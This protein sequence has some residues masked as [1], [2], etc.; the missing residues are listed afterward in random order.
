MNWAVIQQALE[1]FLELLGLEIEF[2]W[3]NS[4]YNSVPGTPYIRVVQAPLGTESLTVGTAGVMG[5]DGIMV[6]GLNYPAG[7]GSGAALAMADAI[8]T[9]FKPGTSIAA[10]SG[11]VL[12]N[13][14]E[15]TGKEASSQPD[16]WV[17][18]V[19]VHYTALHNY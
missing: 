11:N 8:A 5:T 17:L 18:P 19:L 10:G 9:A 2:A 16:W 12:I 13:K 7:E 3:E 1:Q 14:T 6:L 4:T 15:I